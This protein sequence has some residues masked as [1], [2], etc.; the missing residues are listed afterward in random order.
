M[1]GFCLRPEAVEELQNNNPAYRALM[2]CLYA[3]SASGQEAEELGA[4]ASEEESKELG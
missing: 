2:M 4:E 1:G 3:A